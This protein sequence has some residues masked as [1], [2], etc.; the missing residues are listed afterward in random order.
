MSQQQ[1]AD[2]IHVTRQTLSNWEIGRGKPDIEIFYDICKFFDVSADDMLSGTVRKESF[3]TVYERDEMPV[4]WEIEHY[5]DNISDKGFY[6][7]IDEDLQ[8]FFPIIHSDFEHIIVM[9][10]ALKKK[11]YQL[12]EVFSNGFSVFIRNEEEAK[13]FKWDLDGIFEN[14]IHHDDKFVEEK[15]TYISDI[16]GETT[17]RVIN[18][19]MREVLGK[20]EEEFNYYWID[21]DMNTRGYAM[22]EEEC[23]AQAAFQECENYE[24]IQIV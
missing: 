20:A 9:V 10:L 7:I 12:T 17:C 2:E 18:E 21:E 24:I 4:Y 22:S 8:N 19:V 15:M 23:K 1:L 5:I 16:T 14:F 6:T 11:G 3:V 13:K